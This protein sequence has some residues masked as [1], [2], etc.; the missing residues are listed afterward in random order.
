MKGVVIYSSFFPN[1]DQLFR[2]VD[3]LNEME[4]SFLNYR[5]Y[6]GIQVN[7]TPEWEKIILNYKN[8]GLDITYG[9]V[10][11]DLYVNSDVS[12]YQKAIELIIK[13]E[14]SLEGHFV[15]FGHSKGVTTNNLSYHKFSMSSFWGQKDYIEDR[16]ESNNLYG[17]YGTHISFLPGYDKEKILK[18]WQ[19][20][21]NISKQKEVIPYMFVNTF[22]V[23]KQSIFNELLKN[24]KNNFLNEKLIGHYDIVGDRYFFERDFIH[25]VDILGYIPIFEEVSPNCNWGNTDKKIIEQE[26]ELWMKN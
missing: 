19:K 9:N 13:D 2:G 23:V 24:L 6:I 3:F 20:Y 16:L 22:Y 18:I 17:C 26:L 14:R 5:I 15:W 10:N 4:K 1:E 7:T 8:N 11:P 12:G 25:F 21:S